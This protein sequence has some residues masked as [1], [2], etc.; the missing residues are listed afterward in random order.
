MDG[1]VHLPYLHAKIIVLHYF[2]DKSLEDIAKTLD[3][4]LPRVHKMHY[5]AMARL[6]RHLK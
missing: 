5:D 1:L 6:K 2:Q 4:T 3:L